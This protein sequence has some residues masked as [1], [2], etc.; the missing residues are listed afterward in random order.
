MY[1]IVFAARKLKYQ[2]QLVAHL[3][4]ARAAK[5]V[6]IEKINSLEERKLKNAEL[7]ARIKQIKSSRVLGIPVVELFPD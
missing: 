7:I 5:A 6:E 3:N 2:V 4:E 1:C